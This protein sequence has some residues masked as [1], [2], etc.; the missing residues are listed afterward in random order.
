M[1][2]SKRD[3]NEADRVDRSSAAEVRNFGSISG[4]VKQKL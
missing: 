4:R 2:F 3:Y 1:G